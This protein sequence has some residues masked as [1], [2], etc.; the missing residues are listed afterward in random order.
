MHANPRHVQT[1]RR[2]GSLADAA[3]S[4]GV[5]ERTVRRY[6]ADGRLTAFRLGPR[7]VRVDLAEVEAM[8]H[9][10]PTAAA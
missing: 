3:E 8:L 1:A 2:I 7:L 5:N 9:P 6:I 10:I 4:L